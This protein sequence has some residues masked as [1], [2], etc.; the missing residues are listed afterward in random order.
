MTISE[1]S[2][3]YGLP[4]DTLRY[5]E[6]IGLI[7]RVNRAA[8]GNRDY[9]QADLRWVDFV[10]C[11]RAAGLSIETLIEYLALIQQGEG[12]LTERQNLLIEQRD[13]L[14]A[15]IAEMQSTLDRLNMKIERYD[16]TILAAE[17]RLPIAPT[18]DEP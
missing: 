6:R 8:G 15:R 14:A 12:T 3:Q 11:M 13:Q 5:Y 18:M 4:Q 16:Q 17:K 1:V 9:T 2:R 7:P 10:K